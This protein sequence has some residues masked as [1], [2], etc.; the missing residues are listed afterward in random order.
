MGVQPFLSHNR[1]DAGDLEILRAELTIRGAGGWQDVRDLPLGERWAA[2]F[3][4]AI[5]RETGG[6]IW[7]G[8]RKA[9]E[10]QTI[11]RLELPAALRRHRRGCRDS[12]PVVPLFVDL[13]PS[14]DAKL[15]RQAL[16]R[17]WATRL[18]D[19]NGLVRE[20]DEEMTDF[21]ERAA[22]RYLHDVVRGHPSDALRVAITGGRGPT[23]D[24]DLSL[25]WRLLLDDRGS[26]IDSAAVIKFRETLADIREAAQSR[27]PIPHIIVEP[28]LR[29]PLGALV[30][31]EWNRVRPIE[32]TVAQAT[33][34]R[35]FK[36]KDESGDGHAWPEP[37]HWDLEGDGPWVLAVSVGKDLGETVPSY[38]EEHGAAGA[39]HL[40][41]D[42]DQHPPH[43]LSPE[44][45]ASLAQWTVDRL[46]E[47]NSQGKDKHL[48]LLGPVSLAIRIGAGA[49]G[50]GRSWVPLWDGAQGYS[51]G[52][53][54]G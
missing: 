16:G 27:G 18:L 50:T 33:V 40:H 19:L 53:T 43:G 11:R 32:L 22:R 6:F 34:R 12:Y 54:I 44:R 13:S 4:R 20:D 52:V 41:V 46:A 39:T 24:H 47:L 49:N 26:P 8:T 10:S 3:R 23:G 7:W 30:G 42:L 15:I 5:G 21:A 45:I 36:V 2:A 1:E 25:D 28:H 14:R 38:A 48:L 35:T 17:R 29:L 51:A 9:L 37:R 31:W